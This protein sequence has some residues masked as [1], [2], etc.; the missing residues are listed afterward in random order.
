MP[1]IGLD[2]SRPGSN[3]ICLPRRCILEIGIRHDKL[4]I[5]EK[6]FEVKIFWKRDQPEIR[7]MVAKSGLNIQNGDT[8]WAM[9]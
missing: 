5:G 6:R 4:I 7:L 2:N 8:L 1:K 3:I 9:P